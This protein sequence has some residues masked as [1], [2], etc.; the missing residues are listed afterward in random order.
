MKKRYGIISTVIVLAMLLGCALMLCTSAEQATEA[1]LTVTPASGTA[2]TLSGTY[3]EMVEALNGKIGTLG[4]GSAVLTLTADCVAGQPLVLNGTGAETVVIELGGY[5]LNVSALSAKAI[6]AKG[7]ASLEVSGGYSSD[8]EIGSIVSTSALGLIEIE[9]VAAAEIYDVA[10]SYASSADYGVLVKGESDLVIRNAQIAY[11]ASADSSAAVVGADGAELTLVGSSVNASG[12]EGGNTVGVYAKGATVRLERTEILADTAY[13]TASGSW[14]TAV[15]TVFDAERAIFAGSDINGDVI[16][17]AGVTMRGA[18]LGGD[19][20]KDMVKLWYGTGSTL[21]EG[22][23]PSAYVTVATALAEL[24][25]GQ[26]GKWTLLENKSTEVIYTK[27]PDRG[28]VTEAAAKFADAASAGRAANDGKYVF[29]I[30]AIQTKENYNTSTLSLA[31]SNAVGNASVFLDFNGFTFGQTKNT[32]FT[33]ANGGALFRLSIDGADAYGN[34][35]GVKIRGAKGG[36]IYVNKVSEKSVVS[37]SNFKLTGTNGSGQ[38]VT[39][40]STNEVENDSSS[41]LQLQNCR[42]YFDSVHFYY[43]GEEFGNG[44][45]LGLNSDGTKSYDYYYNTAYTAPSVALQNTAFAT[46]KDCT[47][48]CD[49]KGS[50]LEKNIG[51][52]PTAFSNTT[53]SSAVLTS[54]AFAKSCE[55]INYGMIANTGANEH[56]QARIADSTVIS[57]SVPF[58]GSGNYAPIIVTDCDITLA[59]GV[60]LSTGKVHFGQGDGKTMVRVA[61]STLLG[62]AT[63][64]TGCV[65]YFD[66]TAE[67][68]MILGGEDVTSVSMNKLFANGMVFQAGK[69]INVWGGC[70]TDGATITVTLGDKSATVTVEDGKWFVTLDA[71]DYAKGLTL[72]VTEEGKKFGNTVFENVDIGEVWIMSGQSNSNLGAYKME[73]FEEY[74]A[75]ADLYDN[76]RCFSVA[77]A[78]SETPLEDAG[79]A[80][81]FQVTSNTVG[82]A[83]SGCGISAVAYVMATRLAVELDGN[84]TIAVV[85]INY[86]GKAISNFISNNY[87]PLAAS[88]ASEHQ[89]YNAMI[90][91]F[92]GYNVKGFGWYQGEA[93]ADSGE[94]D[95]LGDG[96][97]GLNVDQLYATYTETFNLNEGNEPLELF[98]VQLAAYM[99][100]PSYIRTYQHDIAA[101]NEHYHLI[102]A[103]WAGS[104][105]ANKDFA[106]DAGNGF[107]YG[108]VHAARKSPLGHAWADSILENVYFKDENLNLANPEIE[109]VVAGD[110]EISVTLD[111]DFILM[112][113]D[114][115]EGFEISEDGETWTAAVGRVNGRTITLT[116]DG[117][118]APEYVRYGFGY[119]LIELE[120]GER[121][122]FSKNAATFATDS[123]SYK[124]VTE[125]TITYGDKVYVIHSA[126]SEIIRSTLPGNIVATS[127]HQLHIFS[128]A[129]VSSSA[130]EN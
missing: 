129:A 10:L 62:T 37:F 40:I 70:E 8:V 31:G 91:P 113:G 120:S 12:A 28:E 6:V 127:G 84:V 49:P 48:E 24:S 78:L 59:E 42:Y 110:G 83:D 7:L 79:S 114:E 112:W 58:V 82:R 119:A 101:R 128:T 9:S 123:G 81:W 98:I 3:D 11:G 15:D 111:R 125:V 102:S 43:T 19:V 126:D 17:N 35:G 23:D 27:I 71:M 45:T 92:T 87:D 95:N 26:S 64:D 73:D 116:A 16:H 4:A 33:N 57:V 67:A 18:I 30:A 55:F 122:T 115:V 118:A 51:I 34:V 117:V 124:N 13:Y 77:A 41:L 121:L 94:C 46:A 52:R 85:D 76:I 104:V 100:D 72:T 56:T 66:Q 44:V 88:A 86:N 32:H 60:S 74:K 38:R 25:E 108:Q 97:Y 106:L 53:S 80:E 5:S 130:G 75:L 14:L 54:A 109:E 105:L 1:T 90:A 96:H 89:I 99:S 39:T 21:I 107:Q 29:T 50:I 36:L 22:A 2:Q 63:L 68:Y 65:F 69:P 47:F 103:P 20:T 93:S 61:D